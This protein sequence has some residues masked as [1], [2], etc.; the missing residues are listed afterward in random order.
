MQPI[1]NP[2]EGETTYTESTWPRQ[3][4]NRSQSLRDALQSEDAEQ[5]INRWALAKPCQ[6]QR[7]ASSVLEALPHWPHVLEIVTALSSN[8][9]ARNAFLDQEPQLIHDLIRRAVDA[10]D[11]NSPYAAAAL[12]MLSNALPVHV[13]VPADA[14]TFFALI[15]D[16]AAASASVSTLKPVYT[17]LRGS[18]SHLLGI[19]SSKAMLQLE[20]Q[21]FSILRCVKGDT[22]SL[23][24]YCL[25]ILRVMMAVSEEDFRTSVSSCDTQELLASTS[26][27]SSRWTPDAVRQFFQGEKAQR[28]IQLV[29]LRTMWACASSTGEQFD[30]R[31]ESLRLAN[32]IVAA[33]SVDLRSSWRKA[34]TLL[35]RKLEDKVGNAELEPALRAQGLCFLLQLTRGGFTP[36]LVTEMLREMVSKPDRLSALICDGD[37][38]FLLLSAECGIF[39][40][41]S[42]TA[43][44]QNIVDFLSSASVEKVISLHGAI[45]QVVGQLREIMLRDESVLEGV[46]LALDVLSCGDKLRRLRARTKDVSTSHFPPASSPCCQSAVQLACNKMIQELSKLFLLA[47]QFSHQSSYSPSHETYALLLDLHA[48]SARLPSSCSH[49]LRLP[50]RH[51]HM[52]LPSHTGIESANNPGDWRSALES[53]FICQGRSDATAV[54]A[55]LHRAIANLEDRCEKAEQP[56][57]EEQE[58]RNAVQLQY[59]QLCKAYEEMESES[60]DREIAFKAES[61][62]RERNLEQLEKAHSDIASLSSKIQGLESELSEAIEQVESQKKE[63]NEAKQMDEMKYSAI[64]ARYEEESETT[65]AQLQERTTEI[66]EVRTYMKNVRDELASADAA[67]KNADRERQRLQ[68]IVDERDAAMASAKTEVESLRSHR[69]QLVTDVQILKTDIEAANEAHRTDLS[70]TEERFREEKETLLGQHLNHSAELSREIE[71]LYGKLSAAEIDIRNAA[72]LNEQQ[73]ARLEKR[74]DKMNEMQKQME[75]WYRKCAQKDKQIEEANAMRTN[76]MAAMGLGSLQQQLLPQSKLQLH[77]SRP[78][79]ARETEAAELFGKDPPSPPSNLVAG[80]DKTESGLD[81]QKASFQVSFVSN[82]SPTESRSGPTP[83]RARPR[84]SV[85]A[86]TPAKARMSAASRRSMRLEIASQSTAQRQPLSAVAINTVTKKNDK[87]PSKGVAVLGIDDETT[88]DGSEIFGGTQA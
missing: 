78:S 49:V 16:A 74:E 4:L 34:N 55:I 87:T 31:L 17:L 30:E 47:T 23:S 14:Q 88:F 5:S 57:R 80:D 13:A 12:A 32:E 64:R 85:K 73:S 42:T 9:V 84:R 19:L 8:M 21:I 66:M 81:S 65:R 15:F 33:I 43:A 27:T 86:L 71:S 63:A 53:H 50:I 82:A 10:N 35:V 38:A 56:L 45:C 48:S 24:L 72:R 18:T 1:S 44:I 52:E 83:K 76:L 41:A 62:E 54:S 61:A 11:A 60:V 37:S 40:Q 39:D 46:M 22:S 29:A 58:R 75:R 69:D 36:C 6:V 28:T 2:V 59:G 7:L 77:S 26:L 67:H 20:D 70:R 3:L 68:V 79:V 51:H 25:A